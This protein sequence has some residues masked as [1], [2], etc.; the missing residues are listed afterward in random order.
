MTAL[1]R[2]SRLA[3]HFEA[4][5]SSRMPLVLAPASASLNAS[6]LISEAVASALRAGMPVVALESTIISHGMPYPE[7]LQ[8][9]QV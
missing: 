4:A 9:A 1:Q 5:S 6:L 3:S 7:N 8:C 2:L